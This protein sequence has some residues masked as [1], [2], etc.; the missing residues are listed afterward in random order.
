MFIIERSGLSC[1][2]TLHY[3]GKATRL[4]PWLPNVSNIAAG[5]VL[6]IDKRIHT[7]LQSRTVVLR[8]KNWRKKDCCMEGRGPLSLILASFAFSHLLEFT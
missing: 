1:M 6:W 8:C 5:D 3:K 2:Y 7:T 4:S